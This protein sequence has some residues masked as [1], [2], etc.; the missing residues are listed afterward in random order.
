MGCSQYWS[1]FIS[2]VIHAYNR[3]ENDATGYSPYMLIF[4]REVRLL[5]DL[6][7][8]TFSNQTLVTS[9]RAYVD[10]LRK[11]LEMAYEKAKVAS[12]VR[13]QQDKRNFDL[14]VRVQD[15]KPSD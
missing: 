4:G 11:N 15:L 5:V 10:C 3:T 8:G 9:H 13:G 14:G 12:D 6:T 7:F 1:S 2:A